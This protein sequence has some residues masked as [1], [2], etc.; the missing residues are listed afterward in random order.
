M[1]HVRPHSDSTFRRTRPL[2]AAI[3][4]GLIGGALATAPVSAQSTPP[5]AS[6]SWQCVLLGLVHPGQ[7]LPPA[8]QRDRGP[9]APSDA[10]QA[11]LEALRRAAIGFHS[12]DIAKA[13]GW[14]VPLSECVESPFGGMGYHYANIDQ[15]E[16]GTLSLLR[17]EVLLYAPTADGS[18][19][20]LGV[21]YII[22]GPA[23]ADAEPPHFLGEHLHYNP[24]LDIWAL[25]VWIGREN[26]DGLFEDWNPT[27]SCE[28]AD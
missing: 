10:V 23:W 7:P 8:C 11:Q 18:M 2:A 17:P 28:H 27:V 6:S 24:T 21:E 25:H 9:G 4:C 16:N 26:P 22:P 20:F 1:R 19:E 12:F 3:L 15:L 5:A 13:A 14:N